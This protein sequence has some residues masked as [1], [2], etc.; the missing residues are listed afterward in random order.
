MFP[1]FLYLERARLCGLLLTVEGENASREPCLWHV[2]A[3]FGGGLPGRC[4]VSII[5]LDDALISNLASHGPFNRWTSDVEDQ[6][7]ALIR[8]A[9]TGVCARHPSAMAI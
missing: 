6:K 2:D 8:V 1:S 3:K 9:P 5:G 4:F 7:S